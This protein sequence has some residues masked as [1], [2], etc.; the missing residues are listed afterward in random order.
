[1][2]RQITWLLI[3]F[4]IIILSSFHSDKGNYLITA[5][6]SKVGV[7]A[8]MKILDEGGTAVDAALSVALSEI[9]ETDGKFISY[10][11]VMFLVYYE[12]KTGKIYNMNAS[13]NTIQNETNPLTI[14]SVAYNMVDTLQNLLV[15]PGMQEVK[16]LLIGVL[17]D[18]LLMGFQC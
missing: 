9:A 4:G 8:G 6:M 17:R 1:M 16:S 10:A 3:S 11:G 13:Y 5:S 12:N 14:P 18:Y 2:K 7:D 15:L